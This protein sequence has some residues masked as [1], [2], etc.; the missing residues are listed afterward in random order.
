LVEPTF[1]KN[2]VANVPSLLIISTLK[3]V[4][5]L[6]FEASVLTRLTWH[7][8]PED[9]ILHLDCGL[10]GYATELKFLE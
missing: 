9:G 1:R 10:L 7:R 6:S 2:I 5:T 8:F 3:M 4:A